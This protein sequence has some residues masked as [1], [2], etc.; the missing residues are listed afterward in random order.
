MRRAY[1]L[2]ALAVIAFA[3]ACSR[4][5][6]P[7]QADSLKPVTAHGAMQPAPAGAGAGLRFTAP[8]GWIEETPKSSMRKAQ[9][10]LPKVAGDPEDAELVVFYF[11]GSGGGV[12]ANIDRWINQFT[13]HDGNP[14]G[15]AAK[16]TKKDVNGLPVTEVDVSGTYLASSGPML[17]EVKNKPDFRMLGAVAESASGPWFFKLT[18]P[19]K[20]VAKWRPS[21]DEFVA[22]M[23]Q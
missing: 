14:I 4:K 21:F 6:E 12:Q 9:Y 3:A 18:G 2:V 1:T 23:K 8:E 13:R 5:D 17:A 7:Q 11:G 20:T 16:T 22:T 15:E 19:A 10:R